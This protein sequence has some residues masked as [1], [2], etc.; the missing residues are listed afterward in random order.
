MLLAELV[1]GDEH[2]KHELLM[3]FVCRKIFDVIEVEVAH[4]PILVAFLN[5]LS[6]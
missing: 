5:F 3:F 1:E 2:L 6:F 4:E